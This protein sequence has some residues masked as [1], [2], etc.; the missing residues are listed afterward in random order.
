M[1]AAGFVDVRLALESSDDAYAE[2]NGAKI[3]RDEFARAVGHLYA[4]GFA[5][6]MIKAYCM[7][8]APGMRVENVHETLDFARQLQVVPMLSWYSPVPGSRDFAMLAARHDLTDPLTHNNTAW[9]YQAAPG[10]RAYQELKSHERGAAAYV[11]AL[12]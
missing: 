2:A 1:R 8:N 6:G 4:A 12:A 7:A 5:P 10:E 9:I 11:R 3:T